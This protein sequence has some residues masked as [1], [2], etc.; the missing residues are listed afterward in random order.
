[1]SLLQK[2]YT[3]TVT[4]SRAAGTRTSL[5]D[6]P[7]PAE[8]L[9]IHHYQPGYGYGPVKVVEDE[10][11]V[12]KPAGTGTAEPLAGTT[13]KP[14]RSEIEPVAGTIVE[15]VPDYKG[16][17]EKIAVDKE[18]TTVPRNE[19]GLAVEDVLRWVAEPS[20]GVEAAV[21]DNVP[22]TTPKMTVSQADPLQENREFNLSIGTISITVEE[23]QTGA[24][25]MKHP[26]PPP[27]DKGQ[28]RNAAGGTPSPRLGRHYLRMRG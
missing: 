6:T 26:V 13:V 4:V 28:A 15:I 27:Q 3:R 19:S 10:N 12:K 21:K 16:R 20:L 9:E 24:D 17:K 25:F 2:E 18:T 14:G 11:K 1:M 5:P 22:S 23:P 8:Q 7:Q